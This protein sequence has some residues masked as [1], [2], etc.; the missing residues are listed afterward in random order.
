MIK[1]I[2][3]I[4]KQDSI[5]AWR[6]YFWLFNLILL[7]ISS[8]TV[9]LL[10]DD[11]KINSSQYLFDNSQT[12]LTQDFISFL[13]IGDD[14]TVK[15]KTELLNKVKENKNNIGLI[16]QE[17]N[18]GISFTYVHNEKLDTKILKLTEGEL[19][20]LYK[21]YLYHQKDV[22]PPPVKIETLGEIT[23]PLTTEKKLII[24]LIAME[25]AILGYLF[26]AVIIFQEKQEQVINAYRISP[27]GICSY[28]FGKTLVW[29]IFTIIYGILFLIV[30]VGFSLGFIQWLKILFVLFVSGLFYTL[31]GM[32]IAVYF[33][34][35]SDWT[36]IGL[37][38]III[39]LLPEIYFLSPSFS[40]IIVEW[41]PSYSIVYAVKDILFYP[42][43]TVSFYSFLL[44][45]FIFFLIITPITFYSVHTQLLKER[46]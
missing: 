16:I 35:L 40:A 9:Y 23:N 45:M 36:I 10:P 27:S 4:F 24:I 38:I 18:N 15:S 14:S 44:K 37:G 3:I 41:I 34:G 33:K 39:N 6:N 32:S 13:S 2:F 7:I 31:L 25:V 12:R 20:S 5:I 29:G 30:N 26:I 42:G 43:K 8:A 46:K 28:I 19:E 17:K 21:K 11:V 22:K 1:N